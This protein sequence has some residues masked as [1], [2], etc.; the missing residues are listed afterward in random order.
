[1]GRSDVLAGRIPPLMHGD[2]A[3]TQ[4]DDGADDI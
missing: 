3:V 2:L 4:H 1:V